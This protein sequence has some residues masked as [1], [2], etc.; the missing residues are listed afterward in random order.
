MH[1]MEMNSM[2]IIISGKALRGCRP[3]PSNYNGSFKFLDP[4]N[5]IVY[6]YAVVIG[7]YVTLFVT[8]FIIKT[9]YDQSLSFADVY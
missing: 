3:P 1:E 9:I 2:L 5:I 6:I 7:D 4:D 8:L